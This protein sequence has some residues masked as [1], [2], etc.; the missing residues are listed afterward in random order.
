MLNIL[1]LNTVLASNIKKSLSLALGSEVKNRNM[2]RQMTA[3]SAGYKSYEQAKN[4]LNRSKRIID[5]LWIEKSIDHGFI[6]INCVSLSVYI[7][8]LTGYLIFVH[9]DESLH[10][11]PFPD[12]KLSLM[13]ENVFLGYNFSEDDIK[14]SNNGKKVT[15]SNGDHS[16]VFTRDKNTF[17]VDYNRGDTFQE[18]LESAEFEGIDFV[19]MEK[20]LEQD[21]QVPRLLSEIVASCDGCIVDELSYYGLTKNDLINITDTAQWFFEIEKGNDIAAEDVKPDKKMPQ[22]MGL[23]AY[24]YL[25]KYYSGRSLDFSSDIM[26]SMDIT[27]HELNNLKCM[28]KH[29]ADMYLFS[30]I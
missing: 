1:S 6:I 19:R 15:L 4:L 14:Y 21:V 24:I 13:P 16:L 22:A 11:V 27:N 9:A 25:K 3:A 30:Y 29:S 10:S 12:N 23:V 26:E 18:R 17:N 7:N 5:S 8:T 2:I 28:A 20:W